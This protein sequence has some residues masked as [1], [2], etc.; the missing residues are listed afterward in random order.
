VNSAEIEVMLRFL[1]EYTRI[2]KTPDPYEMWDGKQT[3][4]FEEVELRTKDVIIAFLS[5]QREAISNAGWSKAETN[6]KEAIRR[7]EELS[8]FGEET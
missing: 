1:P 3:A 6:K 7:I 2:I 4:R 8:F 5:L